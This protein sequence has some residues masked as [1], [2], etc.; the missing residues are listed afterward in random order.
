MYKLMWGHRERG[1]LIML[2]VTVLVYLKLTNSFVWGS[3]TGKK[4]T[5]DYFIRNFFQKIKK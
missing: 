3:M 1:L 2:C 4:S 5:N